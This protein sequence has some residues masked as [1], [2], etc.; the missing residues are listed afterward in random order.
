MNPFRFNR[1]IVSRTRCSGL[2]VVSFIA[3]RTRSVALRFTKTMVSMSPIVASVSRTDR[4]TDP[5]GA[6]C[7]F[8]L[9]SCPIANIVPLVYKSRSGLINKLEVECGVCR[10][11]SNVNPCAEFPDSLAAGMNAHEERGV[12]ENVVFPVEESREPVIRRTLRTEWF[13][14]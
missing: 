1:E 10:G 9:S 6:R 12:G 3:L 2:E 8:F 13:S 11:S 4:S 7:F 14:K 5:R